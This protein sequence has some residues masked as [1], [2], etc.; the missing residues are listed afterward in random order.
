MLKLPVS[1]ASA[2]ADALR[3]PFSQKLTGT[4]HVMARAEVHRIHVRAGY[5][6]QVE[7]ASGQD[8][9]GMVLAEQ[10]LLSLTE[11][12]QSL[13]RR[14]D[15][16]YGVGL[17]RDSFLTAD[18]VL[19]GL[20]A[21]MARR[22]ARILLL[23]EARFR[24]EAGALPGAALSTPSTRLHPLELMVLA[25][26]YPTAAQ[27][28]LARTLPLKG[29]RLHLEVAPHELGALPGLRESLTEAEWQAVEALA[30]GT[31]LHDLITQGI[32]PAAAASAL[33]ESL[34]LAGVLHAESVGERAGPSAHAQYAARSRTAAQ[35]PHAHRAAGPT[36][37]PTAARPAPTH[38][39]A[40]VAEVRFLL[41]RGADAHRLLGVAPGDSTE[42]M[43]SAYRARALA[44]HPDRHATGEAPPDLAQLFHAINAAYRSLTTEQQPATR[45]RAV[46]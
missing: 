8:P 23:P 35:P 34:L 24:F 31:R 33:V 42:R 12:R 32:A 45:D 13:R 27:R 41:R 19:R 46:A 11:V 20:R 3:E 25:A 7:L 28:S 37:P 18:A 43:R 30:A 9:L 2:L 29:H 6:V 16:L 14:P 38:Q 10:G 21:Q 39:D 4:L 36:Q 40:V 15:Q 17:V 26:R 1:I 44:L 22:A 5:V